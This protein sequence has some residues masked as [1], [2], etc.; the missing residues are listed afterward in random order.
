MPRAYFFL[1]AAIMCLVLTGCT[2]KQEPETVP[3]KTQVQSGSATASPTSTPTP[4]PTPTSTPAPTPTSTPTPTPTPTS[5]PT[6]APTETSYDRGEEG[7]SHLPELDNE[8]LS[9]HVPSI[10]MKAKIQAIG[11]IINKEG[12]P[13]LDTP[14]NP[15]AVGWYWAYGAPGGQSKNIIF[16]A[17]Y[18]YY[19]N[20]LG[21]FFR[22]IEVAIG[23]E[24]TL[25]L[26]NGNDYT[27]TVIS[28][29]RYEKDEIDMAIVLWPPMQSEN[30]EW[31]TLITCGGELTRYSGG[32]S[33]P[34]YY[35]HRDVLI[36]SREVVQEE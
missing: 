9:M 17:H 11:T 8:I 24:I 3:T 35:S 19:P 20:I 28:N 13:Q 27:Y 12:K 25:S 14:P 33:G 16:S 36:A 4:T 23:E 1:L 5:T 26:G 2:N 18:S 10:T 7:S 30:E 29:T 32:S 6:P 21:P 15:L 34:G 31:I 22:L